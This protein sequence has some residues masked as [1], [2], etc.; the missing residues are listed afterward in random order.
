[1]TPYPSEFSGFNDGIMMMYDRNTAV[2][3]G[4]NVPYLQLLN[5]S[6]RKNVKEGLS[7]PR[8]IHKNWGKTECHVGQVIEP[9]SLGL[10]QFL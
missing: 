9:F 2:L 10:L 6:E 4:D 3:Q 8:D 5:I 7:N 1:M